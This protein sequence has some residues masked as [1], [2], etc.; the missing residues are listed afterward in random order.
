MITRSELLTVLNKWQKRP[1]EY[2]NADCAHFANFVL[3]ELTGR[4][5]LNGFKYS[6][7]TEADEIIEAN[8]S[9]RACVERVLGEPSETTKTGDV[10]LVKVPM[11]EPALGIKYEGDA[12]CLTD[13]GLITIIGSRIVCGWS[14]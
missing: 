3:S 8:G 13:Q 6:N 2:G 11:G 9:L 7:E 5:Y 10:V 14:V 1:F 12:V 4:D